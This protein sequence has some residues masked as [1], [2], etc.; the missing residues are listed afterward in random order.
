MA[1]LTAYEASSLARACDWTLLCRLEVRGRVAQLS[2]LGRAC[3]LEHAAGRVHL[4]ALQ[5]D[6]D[7]VGL[8]EVAVG[9]LAPWQ[10]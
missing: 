6:Q 3:D 2:V 5:V 8:V 1:I 7:R 4:L 10:S 9:S